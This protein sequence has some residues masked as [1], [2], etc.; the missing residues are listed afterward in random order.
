CAR[1]RLDI[2]CDPFFD[3]VMLL[4]HVGKG[5]MDKLV[6]KHPIAIELVLFGM[7]PDCNPRE[8]AI[9]KAPGRAVVDAAPSATEAH[10]QSGAPD[11]KLSIVF[12]DSMRG[13]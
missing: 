3:P 8:S 10:L 1:D 12:S 2:S 11:G 5:H 13:V 6:G 4:R 7:L 9:V